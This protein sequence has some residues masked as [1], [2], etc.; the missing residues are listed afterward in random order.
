MAET[1]LVVL[2]AKRSFGVLV[3]LTPIIPVPLILGL[4]WLAVSKCEL[5]RVG[6]VM[7]RLTYLC[8]LLFA[9]YAT[10]VLAMIYWT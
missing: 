7:F 5:C 3:Q 4:E 9:I 1:Y 8:G 6:A 10:Y 2:V